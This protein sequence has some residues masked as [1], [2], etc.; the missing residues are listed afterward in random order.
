MRM[1]EYAVLLFDVDNTLLDFSAA[2]DEALQKLFEYEGLILTPAIKRQYER[3]NKQLWSS[4]EEG[5]RTRDEVVNTRFSLLLS[6]YGLSGDGIELEK[7]Y[8]R[9][10]E[11]D[12]SL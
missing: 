5:K 1:K 11:E 10:L 12:I 7:K 3:I 4:F 6:E 8:R 9:Y 2:E